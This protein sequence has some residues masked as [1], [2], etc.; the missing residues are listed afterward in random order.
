[1][2]G[3]NIGEE[4][5]TRLDEGSLEHV[6]EEGEHRVQRRKVLL[7]TGLA[8][9]DTSQELSEDSQIQDERSSQER[10]LYNKDRPLRPRGGKKDRILLTSHSLKILMVERPP[11]KISE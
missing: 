6:G 10:I 9:L 2:I 11:Q 1:M 7:L 4:G 3:E 8:V 5:L